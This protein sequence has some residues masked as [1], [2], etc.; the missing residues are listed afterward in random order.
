M[1]DQTVSNTLGTAHI[2]P[3]MQRCIQD[4]NEC[5]AICLET[6]NHGL[7]LGGRHAESVHVRLLL[8]CAEICQTSANFMLR[9]SD[10]HGHI[11]QACAVI[12]ENCAQDCERFVVAGVGT[13]APMSQHSDKAPVRAEQVDEQMKLCAEACRRC[14]ESC[15]QMAASIPAHGTGTS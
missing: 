10:L 3:E 6:L 11:C 13:G 5:H 12:C 7:K 14:A 15:K 1:I 2:S 8:D 4:C 9:G